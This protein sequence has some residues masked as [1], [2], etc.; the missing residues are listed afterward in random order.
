MKR[1]YTF[2]V[3]SLT[4]CFLS[5]L[6]TGKRPYK[7]HIINKVNGGHFPAITIYAENQYIADRI[8]AKHESDY[9]HVALVEQCMKDENGIV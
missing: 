1:L 8:A 4:T 2:L 3:K 5:L 7:V 6:R 9:F